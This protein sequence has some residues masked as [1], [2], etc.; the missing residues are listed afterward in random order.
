MY[1]ASTCTARRS[2]ATSSAATL[3]SLR[4]RRI[5]GRQHRSRPRQ[6]GTRRHTPRHT[7]DRAANGAST[8]TA[9]RQTPSVIDDNTSKQQDYGHLVH[10]EGAEEPRLSSATTVQGNGADGP[11]CKARGVKLTRNKVNKNKGYALYTDSATTATIAPTTTSPQR[12]GVKLVQHHGTHRDE[13]WLDQTVAPVTRPARTARST[14]LRSGVPFAVWSRGGAGPRREVAVRRSAPGRFELAYDRVGAARRWCCCTAA[15]RPDRLHGPWSAAASSTEVVV[16]TCAASGEST[17]PPGP[18]R[19]LHRG[20]PG[21]QRGRA[22]RRARAGPPVRRRLRLGSRHRAGAGRSPA[23]PDR[24]L[25]LALHCPEPAAGARPVGDARSSVT[26][27]SPA[28]AAEQLIDGKPDAVAR[29]PGPLLVA[30]V[31]ARF[32]AGPRRPRAPGVGLRPAGAFHRVVNWYRGGRRHRRRRPD[33]GRTGSRDRICVPTAVLWPEHDPL[34][35]RAWSDRLDEFG[36]RRHAAA[37]RR[38]GHFSPL[39]A[40]RCFAEHVK[41]A[42]DRR[43]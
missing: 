14:N 29:L 28:A 15:G 33:R 18:G 24:A 2:S 9:S 4:R 11:L 39:E 40:R 25:V 6:C 31:R 22:D 23:R 21:P 13:Q 16:P 5:R 17:S 1:D 38:R 26:R 34:L 30:L 42:L 43:R 32:H 12:S 37:R 10:D 27:P 36:L 19:A 41:A 20:R 35:P 7:R 8:S 3:P